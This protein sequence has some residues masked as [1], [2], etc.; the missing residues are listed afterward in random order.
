MKT[1]QTNPTLVIMFNWP[2]VENVP[3]LAKFYGDRFT[4]IF[5][6]L[7][8][9]SGPGL[10][11]WREQYRKQNPNAPDLSSSG[12]QKLRKQ[13]KLNNIFSLSYYS[14]IFEVIMADGFEHYRNENTS[15]YIFCADD[16]LLNPL[17]NEDN[18]QDFFRINPNEGY[19]NEYH[20]LENAFSLLPWKSDNYITRRI[21][22][23]T[24]KKDQLRSLLQNCYLTA[25]HRGEMWYWHPYAL[26]FR[27]TQGLP[28]RNKAIGI[29]KKYKLHTEHI[30]P[31]GLEAQGR[32]TL[33]LNKLRNYSYWNPSANFLIKKLSSGI[34]L[35]LFKLYTIPAIVHYFF[36]RKDSYRPEKLDYPLARSFSDIVI[37]P[38]QNMHKFAHLCGCF[39]KTQL[40]CEIA[41][42]TAL[43]LA[44]TKIRTK[45][46][47]PPH[48][49][50]EHFVSMSGQQSG[51]FPLPAEARTSVNSII[52]NWPK[53][54][55]YI[56]PVK[57]SEVE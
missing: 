30:A 11:K 21:P 18:Y 9:L 6:I 2:H 52:K 27:L 46:D 49:V 24:K 45:K 1:E 48:K 35:V 33:I 28:S 39:A 34:Y 4:R 32:K 43:I 40:F 42:P 55:L 13:Y 31:Q 56:H 29:F 51:E 14:G 7:P 44:Q 47:L 16:L 36:T 26:R 57:L 12:L 20:N 37:V 19:I 50:Y 23:S 15:H 54:Y 8:D 41:I 10:E 5:Y 3:K 25:R 22:P 53:E 17:I 38:Q